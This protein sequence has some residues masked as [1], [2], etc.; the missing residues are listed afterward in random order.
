MVNLMIIIY[1]SKTIHKLF[2]SPSWLV[3]VAVHT[4]N[5]RRGQGFAIHLRG[6]SAFCGHGMGLNSAGGHFSFPP[7][8][9]IGLQRAYRAF[10]LRR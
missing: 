9:P 7:A 4:K 3:L 6:G 10:G 5:G 8:P 2:D 1:I